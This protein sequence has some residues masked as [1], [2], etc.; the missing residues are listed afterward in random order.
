MTEENTNLDQFAE[1]A[2]AIDSDNNGDMATPKQVASLDRTPLLAQELE[3]LAGVLLG[4]FSPALP[5]LKDIYTEPVM[6]ALCE[7]TARVL[8]KY[9]LFADGIGG[10]YAEE[11]ALA[12]VAL[13]LAYA[14]Y[15][16]VKGD[17]EIL[18]AKNN[19]G[20]AVQS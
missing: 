5:S 9:N 13:P 12:A 17:I 1:Q 10:K 19:Q 11:I 7:S 20:L 3:M 14:T 18:K 2:A 16:G 6:T 8:V 4:V 15:K